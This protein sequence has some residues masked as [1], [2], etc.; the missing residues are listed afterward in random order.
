MSRRPE[1]HP[2]ALQELLEATAFYDAEG[3]GLGDAFL[4]EVERG[5]RQITAFPESSP[6]LADP[7]RTKVLAAFPNSIM[8]SLVDGQ[9]V[10]LAFAHRARRPFY[11]RDGRWPEVGQKHIEQTGRQAMLWATGREAGSSCATR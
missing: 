11:R 5:L 9:A 2:A 7:V 6:V 1:P 8:Y 4:D 10:V 3:L